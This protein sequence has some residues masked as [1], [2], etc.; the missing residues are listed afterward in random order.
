MLVVHSGARSFRGI[1][2]AGL[3]LSGL[4]SQ[5]APVKSERFLY[6][7]QPGIPAAI[8]NF[9]QPQAACDWMGIGGQVFDRSGL[10]A[11]GMVVKVSGALEGKSV[12][13]VVLTGSSLQFGPGGFDIYLADHPIAAHSLTLQLFDISG[14]PK[15][16]PLLLQTYGTCQQNLLVVN[17]IEEWIAAELFFP[18]VKK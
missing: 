17:L 1:L 11:N 2:W 10:P 9:V 18:L 6:V 14:V 3:V 13:I 5:S 4:L 12:D 8:H 16:M 7:P 15:S